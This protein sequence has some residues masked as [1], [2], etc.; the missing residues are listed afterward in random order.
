M[1]FYGRRMNCTDQSGPQRAAAADQPIACARSFTNRGRGSTGHRVMRAASITRHATARWRRV[2]RTY[3]GISNIALICARGN[4]RARRCRCCGSDSE[5][6]DGSGRS[7]ATGARI[8]CGMPVS[9]AS[10]CLRPVQSLTDRAACSS[11]RR[12]QHGFLGGRRREA[13]APGCRAAAPCDASDRNSGDMPRSATD[14][15]TCRRECGAAWRAPGSR[16]PVRSCR[17][18]SARCGPPAK[19]SNS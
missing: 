11:A 17:G 15:T 14:A 12:G 2:S 4:R 1:N 16:S 8:I 6:G 18:M 7:R 5:S 10:R 9:V 13:S 3:S 19:W